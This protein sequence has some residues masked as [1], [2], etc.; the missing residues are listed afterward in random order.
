[1]STVYTFQ[2]FQQAQAAGEQ[3]DFVRRFVLQHCAS[4]PYRRT[5]T[6]MTPRKTRG[7]NASRRLT[8]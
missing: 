6:C 2:T 5:L 1:M 4:G 8:L 3:P 7:L